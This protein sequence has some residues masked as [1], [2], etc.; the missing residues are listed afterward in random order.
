MSQGLIKGQKRKKKM[1]KGKGN[2]K[3]GKKEQRY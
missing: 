1:T 2:I 3:K